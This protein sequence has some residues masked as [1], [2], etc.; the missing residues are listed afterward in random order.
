MASGG[1]AVKSGRARGG[2]E[3]SR[4]GF[5]RYSRVVWLIWLVPD[6]GGLF[7]GMRNH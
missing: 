6:V 2:S 5:H 3:S 7:L 1:S 4:R